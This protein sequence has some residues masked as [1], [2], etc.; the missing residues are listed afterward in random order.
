MKS[1]I[2]LALMLALMSISCKES[3][4]P[5]SKEPKECETYNTG[6]VYVENQ[7]SKTVI[8]QIS[9]YGPGGGLEMSFQLSPGG[10]K[11]VTLK[12]GNSYLL[13]AKYVNEPN[14][15]MGMSFTISKCQEGGTIFI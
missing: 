2:L 1:T 13:S 12:A 4:S 6:S 10:R 15:F 5:T 14:T 8:A 7:K 9:T 3:E 11:L